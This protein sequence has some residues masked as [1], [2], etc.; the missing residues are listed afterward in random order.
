MKVCSSSAGSWGT[1]ESLSKRWRLENG[2]MTRIILGTVAAEQKVQYEQNP[3]RSNEDIQLEM[4][5]LIKNNR[6]LLNDNVF[7]HEEVSM[8]VLLAKERILK[9]IQ[10]W[11]DKQIESWSLLALLLQ[12]LKDSQTIDEMLKK[13]HSIQYKEYLK[14]SSNTITTILPTK[15]LEYSLSMGDEHLSTIS[16]M[17]SDEVIK[18]SAKNLVPIPSEYEVTF[19][20]ESKC[21]VPVK[22]ESSPVFTT[23]SNPIFDDNDDFTSSDDELLSNEDVSIEDFKVYSNSLFDDEEINSNKIDLH[24]FN[25]ESNLI[26]SL[27]NRDA[28]FDS[29]PKFDYFKEFSG[30]F[31]PTSIIDEEID[32]FTDNDDLMPPGS[33]NDDY[34][35]E[36]DIHIFEELLSNDTPPIPENKS[37]KFDHHDDSSFP[38][39]PSEP[40]DVE[41][42]FESNSGVLTTNV[43]KGI[44]EHYVLMPNIF[45]T[46]PTFDPLYPVY[47]TL[48][49]YLLENEDKV[50][51]HGMLSYLLVSHRAK[52]TS[53]F[54]RNTMMMY[55]GDI[56]LLDVPYLHYYHP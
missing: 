43:G 4:A 16:E 30:E 47:D 35:P 39:P 15:E 53:D 18:S 21:D 2:R 20:D 8:E 46:L 41:I 48:L 36:W 24:Y 27:S 50:F 52:T 1:L 11:N 5:K 38:R 51:K 26:K 42:F 9:L 6:I 55:G 40:P 29:S 19:D 34:Y 22:D 45:P 49:P 3:Q 33:E 54:S 7:P 32:V 28:L 17:E 56:P 25:A 31:M 37:S 12:L 44:F 13:Q 10:A 14:N 23:F